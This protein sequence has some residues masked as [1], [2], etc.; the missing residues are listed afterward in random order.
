MPGQDCV[1]RYLDACAVAD[2]VLAESITNCGQN[3]ECVEAA[4]ITHTA[5]INAA[6]AAFT[7]CQAQG[8]GSGVGGGGE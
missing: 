3:T 8:G 1:S 4:I 7:A 5:A 2:Q 6:A